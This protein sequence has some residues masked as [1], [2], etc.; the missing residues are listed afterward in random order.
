MQLLK[1]G[2]IA[3][4]LYTWAVAAPA[5]EVTISC[6]AT[7]QERELCEQAATAWAAQSG[8]QVTVV[9][10]PERTNE[11][12]TQ[13]LI[14]LGDEKANIDVY[15]IDVIWPGLLA[16]FFLDLR[17]YLDEEVIA[18]HHP[19]IVANNT[20]DGRLVGMPWYTDLGLLFY[21]KDLLAQYGQAIPKDWSEMADVGLFVQAEE[22]K[23][24]NQDMWG[25]VFQGAAYEGLTCNAL[26]WIDAYGGGTVVNADGDITIDNP[27]AVLAIARAASW[28]GTIAPPRVTSFNEEDARITFQLGNAVFMRNWPYVW[29]PL[30]AADSLVAGKVDVA[31]LPKGGPGGKSSSTLG[32]WQLAVSKTSKHPEEAAE[33]VQY[34]TSMAMQKQHAISGAYLPT[35][36]ALYEDPEVLEANPFFSKI[37]PILEHAVARPSAYTGDKYIAVTT[38]FWEAVHD[39]LQGNASAA[40]SLSA[41]NDQLRLIKGREGW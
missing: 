13:Y 39:V 31:P 9:P 11:R 34:M 23:A 15:Q 12:Y 10:G 7:D 27:Y 5:V 2:T 33:L 8:H 22:R 26:E 16:R 20:V 21:R 36:M 1:W 3:S 28:V 6:G 32:G 18:Q 24:G 4:V 37:K 30:N 14:D 41:L 38:H 17:D 35:I 25:F 29:S 40:D 19:A